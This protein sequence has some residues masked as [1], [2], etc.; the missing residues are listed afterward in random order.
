MLS[1]QHHLSSK[2]S[3]PFSIYGAATDVPVMTWVDGGGGPLS[4]QMLFSEL[5]T[6]HIWTLAFPVLA[7][8]TKCPWVRKKKKL[9]LVGSKGTG[10][11]MRCCLRD[12]RSQVFNATF[13]SAPLVCMDISE[14][15]SKSFNNIF[16]CWCWNNQINC[17]CTWNDF[18]KLLDCLPVQFF[19]KVINL[20]SSFRAE[21][22]A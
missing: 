13:H 8:R 9:G 3:V 4:S 22:R 19:Q 20:I 21:D 16:C 12:Q 14:G 15:F 17:N 10:F 7:K 18:L 5:C 11:F 1:W 2:P 6:G